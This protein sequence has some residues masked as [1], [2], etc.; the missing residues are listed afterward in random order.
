M[1]A[2]E[3]LSDCLHDVAEIKSALFLRHA[4]VEHDL[5]QQVTKFVLQIGEIATRNCVGD[6]V[7]FF[8]RVR[9]DGRKTL[10]Q[11]PGAAGFRCAQ[12]CHDLKKALNFA[13]RCH[14]KNPDIIVATTHRDEGART[15]SEMKYRCERP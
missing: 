5:E 7:G 11:I 4:G 12:R 9:R 10:R 14:R 1:T 8:Q 2:D 3:F 6:L 15:L 13:R